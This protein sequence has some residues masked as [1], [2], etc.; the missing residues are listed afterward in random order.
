MLLQG[1]SK[2][3]QTL[4]GCVC[5]GGRHVMRLVAR[6]RHQ[7][8]ARFACVCGA[9]GGVMADARDRSEWERGRGILLR[10]SPERCGDACESPVGA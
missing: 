5:G 7:A 1:E 2:L 4:D 8:G 6:L 3:R 9:R 10:Q